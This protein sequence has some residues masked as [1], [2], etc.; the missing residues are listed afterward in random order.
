MA[1]GVQHHESKKLFQA[2]GQIHMARQSLVGAESC[3]RSLKPEQS[4]RA[5][6]AVNRS[7]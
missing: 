1:V 4:I 3:R 2:V 5:P 6:S 7:F